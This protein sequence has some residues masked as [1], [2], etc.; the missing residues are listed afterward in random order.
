MIERG[1]P[2]LELLRRVES[3]QQEML[4]LLRRLAKVAGADGPPPEK[5]RQL[6]NGQPH[7]WG[8]EG[9]GWV[10]E[11]PEPRKKRTKW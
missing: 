8:G 2:V 1:D 9:T 10:P 11:W 3:Q 5:R 4:K 7:L 6:I